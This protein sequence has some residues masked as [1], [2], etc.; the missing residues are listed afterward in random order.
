MKTKYPI[1]R[2]VDTLDDLSTIPEKIADGIRKT[3]EDFVMRLERL[4]E[5][6]ASQKSQPGKWSRK[7]ILGHLID[8]AANNHHRFVRAQY[9]KDFSFPPY[10]QTEWVRIQHY[11]SLPWKD[12]LTFWKSYNCHLVHIIQNMP[13]E[14]LQVPYKLGSGEL[15]TIGYIVVDYL[16]HMQHHL[17][18]IEQMQDTID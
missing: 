12:L 6:T 15:V 14:F 17:R 18:Q 5:S 2:F 16:G 1:E 3:V 8:S 10:E 11:Y 13:I 9:V 4:E 7:E